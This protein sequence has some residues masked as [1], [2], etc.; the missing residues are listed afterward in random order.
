MKYNA[1]TIYVGIILKINLVLGT[2]IISI[3]KNPFEI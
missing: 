3:E 1:V 2:L